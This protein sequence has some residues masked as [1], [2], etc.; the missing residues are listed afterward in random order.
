[1]FKIL[2]I[3]FTIQ[4]E[5]AAYA[6]SSRMFC[7]TEHHTLTEH[8]FQSSADNMFLIIHIFISIYRGLE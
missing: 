5:A 4:M 2:V 8:L 6:P 7:K 1:M 3:I